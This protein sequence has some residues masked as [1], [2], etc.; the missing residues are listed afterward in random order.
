MILANLDEPILRIKVQKHV[1]GPCPPE[2]QLTKNSKGERQGDRRT[3]EEGTKVSVEWDLC[4]VPRERWCG[5]GVIGET[6]V[7]LSSSINCQ[8][9][10][11]VLHSRLPAQSTHRRALRFNCTRS[12]VLLST[13][14]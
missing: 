1:I 13:S 14:G 6:S 10:C 8:V 9:S 3:K 5:G 2:Q 11:A 7:E 12:H 4:H